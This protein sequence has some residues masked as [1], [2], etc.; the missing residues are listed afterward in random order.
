MKDTIQTHEIL[1]GYLDKL[2]ASREHPKTICPS[3]VHSS[4]S[5]TKTLRRSGCL[6]VAGAD[7]RD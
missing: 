3:E 6:F 2:L 5:V 7:A 1:K 4:S